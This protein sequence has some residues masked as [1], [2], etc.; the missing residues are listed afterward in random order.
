MN[1]KKKA[2]PVLLVTA[3]APSGSWCLSCASKIAQSVRYADI[4]RAVLPD[5]D[6]KSCSFDGR[7]SR[8]GT[9]IALSLLS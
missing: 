9:G 2:S 6:L 1:E 7:R 3:D 5:W 8:V 4:G